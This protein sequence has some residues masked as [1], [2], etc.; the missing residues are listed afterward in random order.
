MLAYILLLIPVL[1]Q[2]F[3]IGSLLYKTTPSFAQAWISLIVGHLLS[4]HSKICI[5]RQEEGV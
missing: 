3:L 1:R 2:V 4:F 5:E